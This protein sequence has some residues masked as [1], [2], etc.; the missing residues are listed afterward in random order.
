MNFAGKNFFVEGCG[1][2]GVAAAKLLLSQGANVLLHD[3]KADL[4]P[5][6]IYQKL[7]SREAK[8]LLGETADE[9][10]DQAEICV[11][12]PGVP[13]DSPLALKMKEKKKTIW[14]EI[15]LAW[16]V[17]PEIMV[18]AIT[19]TNGK[20]T[21]T[22]LVGAIV[23]RS[24]RPVYVVGNIGIPYTQMV[25][26]MED[27]AI[28]VAEISSFQ[29]ETISTFHPKLTAI[30]NL[31]PDHLDRHHTMENYCLAKKAI[32]KNQTAEE[33][34]VL[35][36]EDPITKKMGEEIP[37][38]PF[39]FSSK[40]RLEEGVWLE[41]DEIFYR[42]GQETLKICN[43][44]EC[45]LLG[46]HNYEN[47]CAAVAVTIHAGIPV[48]VVKEAILEFR[49]VEH[50]IEF[51]EEI[52]GV[53]YYNDSKG[54]NPDA[55]IKGIQAMNTKTCLIGGGYDKN[56]RYE[57]WIRSFNGKVKKLV[58]IGQTREKIAEAARNCG[59]FDVELAD[60]LEE[61]VAICA[62][63]AKPGESVLLSPACASWGM[64]RNY[65]ERGNLFKEIVRSMK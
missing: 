8:L 61:A 53:S 62:E 60:S 31:T 13:L 39:Y 27:D 34:C 24:G 26:E 3:A 59:F 1:I 42:D 22:S 35:N 49:A 16:Q 36:Y 17:K 9:A 65:E 64:F 2:S 12:S 14:G 20:T 48:D 63:T 29:L 11:L 56:S 40:R 51:V 33:I 55:A 41:G 43:V 10:I 30:L 21:T 57:E 19:G 28:V 25:S 7:G 44:K 45:H 23:K 47:I 5:E 37:C 4:D 46:E 18:L 15:E 32:T 6:V 54:T 58:L 52:H 38:R 50:R